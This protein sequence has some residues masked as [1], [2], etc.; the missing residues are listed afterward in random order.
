MNLPSGNENVGIFKKTLGFVWRVVRAYFISIG[1]FWN[2]IVL[3][4]AFA[5]YQ[6][7][8]K[9]ADKISV[10]DNDPAVE[11][12][13][14]HYLRLDLSGFFTEYQMSQREL[15]FSRLLNEPVG[16]NIHNFTRMLENIAS[17]DHVKGVL[18]KVGN[19]QVSKVQADMIRGALT[20]IKEAEKTVWVHGS[21][22]DFDTYYM[23]SVAD[24]IVL[25][26]GGSITL[27]GPSSTL[28][29][30]GEALKKVGVGV[31]VIRAGKYKSAFEAFIENEPSAP[32]KEMFDSLLE[33]LGGRM[34]LSIA[35]DR[36][37]DNPAM[38]KDWLAQSFYSASE[39]ESEGIIDFTMHYVDYE[40]D[41]ESRLSSAKVES[42]QFKDRDEIELASIEDYKEKGDSSAR[43]A[44]MLYEGEIRMDSFGGG[45]DFISPKQVESDVEWILEEEGIKA[46]VVRIDSPGGSALASELMWRQLM[47]LKEKMPVI[48][49]LGE[50]AASG[51][52]Y[53][54]AAGSKI[55]A[56]PSTITG[57]IGVIGMVLDF[58]E[59]ED[60]YGLSFH[61]FT[62]SKRKGLL[63][64]GEKLSEEDKR[65]VGKSIDE[66]YELFLTRVAEAR[67]MGKTSVH[68]IAQ[69][70]V[71]TGA[72][73]L[74]VGLAD[75]IGSLND[76]FALAKSESGLD[77]EKLYELA[78]PNTDLNLL[79]CIKTKGIR[80]CIDVEIGV[81]FKEDQVGAEPLLDQLKGLSSVIREIER[82]PLQA[83]YFGPRF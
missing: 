18:L 32:T 2:L 7:G 75:E 50:V 45:D 71:W 65:V 81:F 60:K 20:K 58:A 68:E 30:F 23:L 27:V 29:Y 22:F 31:N 77:P 49:S 12:S 69:G 44:Y 56:E 3:L 24:E 82:S 33:S 47:R 43:L 1:I 41:L 35:K 52:Y 40:K 15:A 37:K 57:S 55:I 66:V 64:P 17:T 79:D 28:M 21:Y 8:T 5:I 51:G 36:A 70:R 39:A 4:L 83:R 6:F 59:F 74:E 25:T 72:Q 38:V 76:A 34:V 53:M 10:I 80:E 46:A 63:N 54:A 26:P 42:T 78:I 11:V 19:L 61:S 48:V 73:A 16:R 67:K 62:D 13:G 9:A 14:E